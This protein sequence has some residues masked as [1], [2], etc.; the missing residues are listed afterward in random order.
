MNQSLPS[1]NGYLREITRTNLLIFKSL[2][3]CTGRRPL[4]FHTIHDASL[5]SQKFTPD[6]HIFL[7]GKN[8]SFY[9][10]WREKGKK[11]KWEGRGKGNREGCREGKREEYMEEGREKEQKG[12]EGKRWKRERKK[13]HQKKKF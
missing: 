5:N 3:L 10:V 13:P 7:G 8:M 4:K 11:E 9:W 12:R 1:F 2:Y 6:V